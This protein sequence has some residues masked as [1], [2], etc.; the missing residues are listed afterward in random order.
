[1]RVDEGSRKTV[2]V[3]FGNNADILYLL[4]YQFN[5]RR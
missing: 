3:L 2:R 4:I 5:L 1:M